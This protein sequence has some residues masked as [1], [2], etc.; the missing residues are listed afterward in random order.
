MV[1]NIIIDGFDQGLDIGERAAT[2][3][4]VGNLT[5]PTFDHIEPR[6]RCGDEMQRE[7]WVTLQ[8]GLDTRVFMGSIVV[9]D[10]MQLQVGG[11]FDINAFQEPNKFLMSVPGHAI[12]DNSAIEHTKGSK[13]RSSPVALI[14]VCLAGR[15]SR[16]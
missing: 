16:T 4:L 15:Q 7:A 10:Q 6:T 12:A 11:Y 14:V 3:S 5:K 13:E 2:Q 8:P 1:M 9:D